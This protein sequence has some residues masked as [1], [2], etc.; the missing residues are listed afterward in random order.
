[1]K[2]VTQI[3]SC[4]NIDLHIFDAIF[5]TFF[6]ANYEPDRNSL[7]KR[8]SRQNHRHRKSSK[9]TRSSDEYPSNERIIL[10]SDDFRHPSFERKEGNERNFK[11]NSNYHQFKSKTARSFSIISNFSEDEEPTP[12]YNHMQSTSTCTNSR[13]Y[14]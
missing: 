1:M 4:S 3:V 6:S 9:A 14:N 7:I 11:C 10:S 8:C 5:V 13:N 2:K 12:L